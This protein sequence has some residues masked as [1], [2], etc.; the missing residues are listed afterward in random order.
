MSTPQPAL[1]WT[2]FIAR[3]VIG[4]A[5]FVLIF[6]SLTSILS[7]ILIPSGGQI[8]FESDMDGN[9]DIFLM[10]VNRNLWFNL[11]QSIADDHDPS[12]SASTRQ[13]AFSSD[14]DG[15]ARTE[16]YVMA[17]SG[18]D[19]REVTPLN[20]SYWSPSWSPDGNHLLYLFNYGNIHILDVNVSLERSLSYGFAP[21][22]SPNGQ[23]IAYYADRPRESLNADIYVLNTN[24]QNLHNLT[25]DD[26]HD[27]EPAWSPDSQQIAFVSSRDGNAEIYVMDASCDASNHC[28]QNVRRLTFNPTTDRSPVWS[29]DGQQIAF[30]SERDGTTQIYIVNLDGSN[31]RRLTDGT[32]NFRAPVW[33]W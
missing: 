22:W 5:G 32:A 15:N 8:I 9:W 31:M 28:G 23:Q 2:M 21:V 18:A 27:W 10:D 3:L 17:E 33:M 19:L 11:T 1:F 29:P 14:R 4:T 16:I 13:I 20:G 12:W 30:E 6:A 26:A 24:G 25:Q 7:R